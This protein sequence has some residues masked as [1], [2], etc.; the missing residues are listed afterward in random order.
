MQQ[1]LAFGKPVGTIA[2]SRGACQSHPVEERKCDAVGV[3][4][5]QQGRS[6][7]LV[8][9]KLAGMTRPSAKSGYAQTVAFRRVFS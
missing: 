7:R 4:V 5:T 9:S 1:P 8:T 6:A 3:L 2:S